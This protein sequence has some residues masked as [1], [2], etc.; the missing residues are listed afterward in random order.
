MH[1]QPSWAACGPWAA[2]WTLLLGKV[3][4]SIPGQGTHLLCGFDPQSLVCNPWSGH[5][6]MLLSLIDVTLS[7]FLS[8][9]VMKKCLQA[10]IKK[11]KYSSAISDL[12]LLHICFI[13]IGQRESCDRT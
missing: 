7:P 9:K 6:L 4:G 2:G 8:L 12:Q 1:S 10:S 11:S 13:L 5:Q 3:V